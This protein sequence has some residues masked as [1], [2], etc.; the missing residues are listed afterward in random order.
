[1]SDESHTTTQVYN[2]PFYDIGVIPLNFSIRYEF[3]QARIKDRSGIIGITGGVGGGK[4]VIR[5]KIQDRSGY[6]KN[7]YNFLRDFLR[8]FLI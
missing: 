2:T 8:D 3:V 6:K 4:V 1:M 7:V 5:I